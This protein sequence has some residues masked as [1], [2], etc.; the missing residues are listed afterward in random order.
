MDK[1]AETQA[2]RGVA[3]GQYPL[4][5]DYSKILPEYVEAKREINTL[6]FC[7]NSGENYTGASI[8][9]FEKSDS[10]YLVVGN[11]VDQTAPFA[12]KKQR[13]IFITSTS[14]E[15]VSEENTN[16]E[17]LTNYEEG[18][19]VFV[20]TPHLVKINDNLFVV[21]WNTPDP[22]HNDAEIETQYGLGNTPG[23][24][25]YVFVDGKGK[26]L[27]GEL[28]QVKTVARAEMS[29][30]RPVVKDQKIVWRTLY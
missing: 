10:S 16:I 18:E 5:T 23:G 28:G 15:D 1:N 6:D 17:W 13:N 21:M 2:T 22:A 8:G 12:T 29:G 11:S 19:D 25:T 4:Y 7:G 3:L 9:G 27:D 24:V 20:T 14:R 26:P 30:C